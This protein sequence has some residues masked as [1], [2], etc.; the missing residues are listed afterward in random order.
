MS[1]LGFK[2][3]EEPEIKSPAFAGSQRKQGNSRKTP[4]S[5]LIDYAKAFD[6]VHHSKLW[7]ILKQMRPDHLTCLWGNL[8]TSQE[9]TVRTRYGTTDWF[10]IGKGVFQ[11]YIL[12]S[13][14]VNLPA[15]YIIRNASLD[16]S[17]AGIKIAGEDQ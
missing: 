16:E 12:S 9:V 5:A 15:E 7:K 3:E 13:C 1:K 4:I 11:G 2:K 6:F 10:Q 8:Y 17:Q 14:V